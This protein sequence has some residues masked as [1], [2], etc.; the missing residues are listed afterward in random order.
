MKNGTDKVDASDASFAT[1]IKSE[2]I[3]LFG[4]GHYD[5]ETAKKVRDAGGMYDAQTLLDEVSRYDSDVWTKAERMVVE[6]IRRKGYWFSGENHQDGM[7]GM[8]IFEIDGRHFVF[9]VSWRHWGALMAEAHTI[10]G[11]SYDYMDFY[12]EPFMDMNKFR[13]PMVGKDID[14]TGRTIN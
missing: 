7:F 8:P 5:F 2:S 13:M 11:R 10:E 3:R 6:E 1:E 14:E 9:W 12:M 4:W